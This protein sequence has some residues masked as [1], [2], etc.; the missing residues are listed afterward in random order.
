MLVRRFRDSFEGEMI[1][2]VLARVSMAL[3]LVSFCAAAEDKAPAPAADAKA[4]ASKPTTEGL[5]VHWKFD[6]AKGEAATDSSE[7]KN[8]GTLTNSPSWVQGKVGG[9]ISFDEGKNSSAAIATVAGLAEG[10]TAHTISAW[11]KVTKLPENRAWILLLGNEGEGSHHWLINAQGETQ[12]GVWGGDQ[13]KPALKTGEWQHI[14]ITY[15]GTNLKSYVNG[16]A[17]ETTTA[18]FN[19][20]GAPLTVAQAHNN[21]NSFE[22]QFDDVR[23]Y[24]R[25]LTEKEVAALAK[26]EAK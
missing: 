5:V 18:T 13:T 15:D 3:M 14:A 25:A 21:E 24:N 1:M 16:A 6:D 8:N 26:V 7:K 4:D 23:V 17:G 19:L 9:A 2:K 10:N 20:Q 22:G 12:F 11:I